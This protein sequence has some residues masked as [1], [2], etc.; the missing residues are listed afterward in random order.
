MSRTVE[1]QT[2]PVGPQHQPHREILTLDEYRALC[3]LRQLKG[4]G[5]E[6]AI[7]ALKQGMKVRKVED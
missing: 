2:T 5:V 7:I 6:I 3:R 1:T 4:Q